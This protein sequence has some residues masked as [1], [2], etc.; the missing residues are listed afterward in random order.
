MNPTSALDAMTESLVMKPVKRLMSGRTTL[1]MAHRL[2]TIRHA[3]RIIVLHGGRIVEEGNHDQLIFVSGI[4]ADL[5][6]TQFGTAPQ[7]GEA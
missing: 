6:R 5:Y 4:Y 3:T 1:V 2:S 7:G